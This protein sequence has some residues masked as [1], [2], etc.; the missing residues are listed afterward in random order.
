MPWQAVEQA[1]A[2]PVLVSLSTG[3]VQGVNLLDKADT[4]E[5]DLRVDQADVDDLVALV[6]PG[7]V[8]NPDALRTDAAA[9][10]FVSDFADEH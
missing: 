6:L 8:A 10:G 1:G 7:G 2:Q 5:V 4:F 3:K 9:V